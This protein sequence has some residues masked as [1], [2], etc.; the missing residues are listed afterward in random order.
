MSTEINTPPLN[1]IDIIL[2]TT[3]PWHVA[4]PDNGIKEKSE[5]GGLKLMSGTL[6][7]RIGNSRIPY[8]AANGIRGAL[9]RHARDILLPYLTETQGPIATDFFNGLSCGAAS[10]KPDNSPNSIEEL[11]RSSE[12]IYMGLFGGGA[13]LMSSKLQASDINIICQD[14]LL[15]HIVHLSEEQ[16]LAVEAAFPDVFGENPRRPHH[17]VDVRHIVRFDDIVRGLKKAEVESIEGGPEAI[18][19]HY[20]A[21]S[22]NKKARDGGAK[23]TTV[24]NLVNLEVIPENTPLHFSLSFSPDVTE[25]QIGMLVMS[26]RALLQRN[27]FGGY[28][29]TGFGKARA[30]AI[31]LVSE[32]YDIEIRK[33]GDDLYDEKGVFQLPG[34]F[35]SLQDAALSEMEVLD[36]EEFESYFK[37]IVALKKEAS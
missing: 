37:D 18:A 9:R 19:A 29:R 15:K 25:A 8:F 3:S 16:K 32:S 20:N 30:E 33:G 17:F 36:R 10:G 13:R 21:I 4:Y 22:E 11:V 24:A 27:Y 31:S 26:L 34:E 7:K 1:R 23:K 35:K 6:K 5:D 28:G 2:R 14:T 12:H